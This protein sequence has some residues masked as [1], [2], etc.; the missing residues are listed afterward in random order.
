MPARVIDF[1]AWMNQNE[2]CVGDEKEGKD[3]ETATVIENSAAVIDSQPH[4]YS[5]KVDTPARRR[6]FVPK[7]NPKN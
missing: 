5:L 6:S 4:P 2:K 7:D 3:E 1:C